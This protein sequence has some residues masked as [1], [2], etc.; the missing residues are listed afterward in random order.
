MPTVAV[1]LPG[2]AAQKLAAEQIGALATVRFC[3]STGALLD[4]VAGGGV[5]AVVAD[6]R[7]PAGDSI[8]PTFRALRLRS[9]QLPLILHCVPTPEALRELPDTSAFRHG[10]TLV[11]RNCEH[12]GAALRPL[13]RPPRVP[14]AAETLARH[15]VP[16]V[17]GPFRPFVLVCA[18]KASPRLRVGTAARWSGASRR[19]LERSL[20]R[21]RLPSAGSVLGSCTA[22][23]AAWWLD[24]QGWSA[25]QVVTE[26][27]FTY[28]GGLTRVLQHYFGCSVKSLR[29]VGGF[30][31]LLFRFE[32]TLLGD[33]VPP[34][35]VQSR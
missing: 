1:M 34:R 28:S 9:P 18:L 29:A 16:L 12:L 23:H 20:R 19:T 30:Q 2:R 17:P 5:D 21:A 15:I 26:M 35:Q 25:K 4:L 8:L 3:E 27:R 13:L 11:F 32:T 6:L 10:L 7:D 33:A 24:V 14:T 22:L 31:E